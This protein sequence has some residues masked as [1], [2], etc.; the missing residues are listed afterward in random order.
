MSPTGNCPSC[1]ATIT[2]QFSMAVQTTCPFCRS[3]LVRSDLDLKK[4]GEVAEI[5]ADVSPIQIRTEGIYKGRAFTVAGRIVYEYE[6]GNWNEW[7]I[8]FSDGASGWLSDAQAL[9]VVTFLKQTPNL[10]PQDQVFRGKT[11]EFENARYEVTS[12]TNANYVG[13]EGELPFEYWDKERVKFGDLRTTDGRFGTIDYSEA[14]P[15]LFLGEA[16]EFDDLKL[17][18]IKDLAGREVKAKTLE[19]PNCGGPIELRAAEVSVTAVCIQCLSVLDSSSPNLQVIQQ[20]KKKQRVKPLVPL[21]TTG[22]LRGEDYLNIGFQERSIRVDGTRYAWREYVL[23]HPFRGFRYLSEYDGHWN[24]VKPLVHLP[25]ATNVGGRP[26]MKIFGETY[27][28]FQDAKATTDFVMGEFPWRVKVGE[29]IDCGDYIHPPRML[30]SEKSEGEVTWSLGEYTSGADIWKA[31]KL[32]G[33]PPEAKGVYANQPSPHSTSVRGIWTRALLLM[34]LAIVSIV[35]A[36]TLMDNRVVYQDTFNFDPSNKGEASF[37]TPVFELKG[38]PANLKVDIEADLSNNWA[39]FNLALVNETTGQGWDWGRE[40]S[41]YSGSDSDGAWSEGS[42]SD[43]SLLGAIPAGRY[44]LRIEPDWEPSPS[45]PIVRPGRI[46]YKI[47]VR[48]DVPQVWF[49]AFVLLLLLI[50]PVWMT[51]RSVGYERQ[52]WAES[53]YGGGSGG[54]DEDEE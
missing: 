42:R 23:F 34:G 4:V 16:V 37:V 11:F 50:P 33:N 36:E 47:T 14:T 29:V 53:Q 6:Q 31:F 22:H 21:G 27:S 41:Y 48:R 5:P 35:F 25:E 18:N 2:F 46:T 24:F 44:Y 17:K 30:S 12:I 15:L 20:F 52:R 8:V 43:S 45:E 51:F 38:R 13:V 40:L 54:D 3:I 19:C 10:P 39:Y 1:G 32:P 49:Y 26:A 7:H 9:Y 28:H